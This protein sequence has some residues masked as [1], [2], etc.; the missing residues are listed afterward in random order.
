MYRKLLFS[1][2]LTALTYSQSYQHFTVVESDTLYGEI[3]VE[4]DSLASFETIP[5][6]DKNGTVC[7]S[8]TI[9]YEKEHFKWNVNRSNQ[10]T[11]I[12][13]LIDMVN[14]MFGGSK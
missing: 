2:L 12:E 7:G 8:I 4:L 6:Y 1:L 5:A 11:D 14:Y 9:M 13:D 3:S 10:I